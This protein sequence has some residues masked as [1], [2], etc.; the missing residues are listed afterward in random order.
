MS[1]LKNS[2]NLSFT[3]IFRV[4]IVLLGLFVAFLIRDI[5]MLLFMAIILSSAF[6]PWV[7]WFQK[8]KISRGISILIMYIIVLG[9]IGLVVVLIIPPMVEQIAQLAKNLPVYYGKVALELGKI[10]DST[11]HA[12][13]LPSAFSA[14]NS[15]SASFGETSKSVFSTITGIF[16][17]LVSF[18]MLLVIVFYITVEENMLK[19][20]VYAFIPDDSRKYAMD[21][22][23]RM[24]KKMG[25]WLRGQISL[26]LIIGIVTYVLLT[27]LGVKYALVL[28]IIAGFLE[29]V[30]FIG[31]W[32]SAV[33]AILIGFSDSFTKVIMI[34]V[35]YFLIQQLENQI[36]VPK[37]MQKAVGL[38][39]IIVIVVVLIGAKIGGI[40]GALV[41]V[42]VAAAIAVYISDRA[43]QIVEERK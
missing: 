31:P 43:P 37:V 8:R 27:I 10:T 16:G 30:P 32:L 28:A 22:V 25:M 26:C 2:N 18:V 35:A 3:S 23:E 38:N 17:G 36:V 14:F 21:L 20:T 29:A 19:K 4:L 40:A 5:I 1:M 15:F 42:P 39:P 33:P 9:I 11:G 13:T 6:D 24:Q 12:L 34:A 7:D 41:A